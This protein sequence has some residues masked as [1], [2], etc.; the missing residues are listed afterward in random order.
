MVRRVKLLLALACVVVILVP[1][2]ARADSMPDDVRVTLSRYSTQMRRCYERGLREQPALGGKLVVRFRVG[3]S[4]RARSIQMVPG[5]STL[6]HA[7]VEKCVARV[8]RAIRFRSV[9]PTW[10]RSPLV[11]GKS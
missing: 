11:F 5:E 3:G 8:F 7:G 9:S 10:Y 4:G 1:V 2:P 6:H